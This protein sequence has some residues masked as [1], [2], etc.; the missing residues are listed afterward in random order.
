MR[1]RFYWHSALG[2]RCSLL[3]VAAGLI[4]LDPLGLLARSAGARASALGD[5]K[6]MAMLGA[7]LG[8]Q[9]ALLS[10]GIGVV[11]GA[12][13]GIGFACSAV[14]CAKSKKAGH[15]PSCRW[16]RFC[17]SAESS[18]ALWGEPMIDA[19]LRWAGF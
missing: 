18:A 6:L 5:A 19:Y 12:V 10:F 4:L 13:A 7:W 11:L 16:A 3:L 17:A 1:N 8:L 9:G 14:D 15:S 2:I